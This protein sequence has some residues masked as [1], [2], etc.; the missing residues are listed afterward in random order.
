MAE[1][2]EENVV[3][4]WS[5]FDIEKLWSNRLYEG[6]QRMCVDQVIILEKLYEELGQEWRYIFTA[7]SYK[8]SVDNGYKEEV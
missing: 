1:L 4:V 7:S 6:L 8:E 2:Y 5:G 3:Y